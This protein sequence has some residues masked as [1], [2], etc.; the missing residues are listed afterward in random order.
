MERMKPLFLPTQHPLMEKISKK[1]IVVSNKSVSIDPF[2][3]LVAALV[4][5]RLFLQ[6]CFWLLCHE[7]ER[8]PTPDFVRRGKIQPLPLH[9]PPHFP[10]NVNFFGSITSPSSPTLLMHYRHI[11]TTEFVVDHFGEFE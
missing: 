7:K 1:G 6:Q 4:M 9:F 5:F 2:A 11:R 8:S 10:S 3:N